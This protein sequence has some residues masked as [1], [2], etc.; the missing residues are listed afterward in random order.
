MADE[1][2][3]S[4]S[5]VAWD[6]AVRI[7]ADEKKPIEERNRAYWLRLYQDCVAVVAGVSA[8]KA[9]GRD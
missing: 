9:L 6:L 5:A 2:S 7:A 4:N 8:E 3:G 1:T